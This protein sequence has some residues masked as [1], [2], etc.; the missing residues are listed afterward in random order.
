MFMVCMC[1]VATGQDWCR[2]LLQHQHLLAAGSQ[3]ALV[4]T[5]AS[6]ACSLVCGCTAALR[7]ELS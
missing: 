7:A 6:L 1:C 3:V 4:K 2:G 5:E